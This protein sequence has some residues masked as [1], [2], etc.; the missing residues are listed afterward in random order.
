MSPQAVVREVP[1]PGGTTNA[2]RVSRVGDT[3]RR[4]DRP[5]S[6]STRALLD[7]LQRIGFDG[8]PRYLGID[9]HGREVLTYIPGRA[10]I[11]PTP[12][13]ALSDEALTSVA[14]LLRRYHDAVQ[15]FDPTGYEW[16]HAVPAPFGQG[17][18]SHNDPNL[19]NIIFRDGRAVAL[20][21]FDLA[22][23]GSRAWDLACTA[24]LW[25]PLRERRD[26]PEAVGDRL[27][28]RLGTFAD[29]YGATREDRL[30]LVDAVAACHQWCYAI[31]RA[32]VDD[33]HETFS[34]QWRAGDAGRAGRTGRW[35]AARAAEMRA[36]LGV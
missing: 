19:D 15:S 7:H 29:A 22:S 17:L 8:A 1:L 28:A 13:W 9:D 12:A 36:A 34:R 20:I 35:L 5:T 18:I 23:P 6:E 2:G 3:V 16:G 25:I 30:G 32:A 27:F 26:A 24:R 21:D 11:A 31:V 33:G 14:Q 10:P 4:P